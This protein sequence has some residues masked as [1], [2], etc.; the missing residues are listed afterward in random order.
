MAVNQPRAPRWAWYRI[1]RGGARRRFTFVLAGV[2][3][4]PP[5]AEYD[6]GRWRASAGQQLSHEEG[7]DGQRRGG[8]RQAAR[9]PGR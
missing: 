4:E 9:E 3:A 6:R 2:A 5:I 8:A 7:A 1:L